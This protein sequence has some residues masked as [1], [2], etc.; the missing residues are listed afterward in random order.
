MG[1]LVNASDV[2]DANA[3]NISNLEIIM[4]ASKNVSSLLSAFDSG[5][6]TILVGGGYDAVRIKLDLYT[7]LYTTLSTLCSNVENA[8]KNANNSMLNYMEGYAQLDDSRLE[9]FKTRLQQIAGY[10]KYAREKVSENSE[11]SSVISYWEGIYRDLDHYKELLENLASTD[12]GLFG[13]LSSIVNDIANMAR[14]VEGININTFTTDGMNAIRNGTESMYYFDTNLRI[15]GYDIDTSNMSDDAK[16]LLEMLEEN[17]PDDLEPQ[18][19]QAMQTALSLLNK[20]VTY[21]M[22]RRHAKDANG[23]PTSMD[24]SSFVTYCLT[25]AG[26]DVPAGAYTGTYLSS[27][28][29]FKAI[30]RDQLRP[31]DVGL[32]NSTT[33]GGGSNHI[34]MYLGTDNN[35]NEVWIECSGKGIF[36]GAKPGKWQ[37]F[38]RYTAYEV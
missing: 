1:K 36:Y 20:G 12:N 25:S 35:G 37:V 30:P 29:N 7:R 14:A 23:N 3:T 8:I 11:L 15:F 24:C 22:P 6:R 4:N 9:E 28:S 19:Y 38:R 26:Y 32:I 17:W 10:L 13:G 18:R 2:S 33:A 27:S 5:S 31:G 16:A 21:S 34:G